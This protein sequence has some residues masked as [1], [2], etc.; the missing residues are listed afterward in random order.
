MQ[1]RLLVGDQSSIEI[2]QV[3]DRHLF[4]FELLRLGVGAESNREKTYFAIG[5][6]L[7]IRYYVLYSRELVEEFGKFLDT[8]DKRTYNPRS[9]TMKNATLPI[10]L[11]RWRKVMMEY[12]AM[13]GWDLGVAVAPVD[14]LA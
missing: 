9:W 7:A 3:D 4:R 1:D 5:A 10:A 2:S 13:S 6:D 8:L 14:S 12:Q 11:A